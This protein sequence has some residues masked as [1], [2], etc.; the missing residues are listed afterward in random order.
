M[1]VGGGVGAGQ[2]KVGRGGSKAEEA[3]GGGGGSGRV[4]PPGV[5]YPL[6]LDRVAEH[7]C[8]RYSGKEGA[9]D[10]EGDGSE[11]AQ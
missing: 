7:C 4:P 3:R 8:R 10:Q 9:H 5:W 11:W 2:A 1:G 6:F